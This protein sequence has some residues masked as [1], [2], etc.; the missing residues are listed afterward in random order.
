MPADRYARVLINETLRRG[1]DVA[2]GGPAQVTRKE[3]LN[4]PTVEIELRLFRLGW[5]VAHTAPCLI[6]ALRSQD[7]QLL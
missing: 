1:E 7:H 5:V 6:C 4:L 3:T 2:S